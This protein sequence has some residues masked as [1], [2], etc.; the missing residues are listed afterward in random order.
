MPQSLL[1][2]YQDLIASG[3]IEPEASQAAAVDALQRLADA[4][5]ANQ[6]GTL[7]SLWSRPAAVRGLYLTGPVG[8]GKTM[9]MDLFFRSV[10]GKIKRRLHFDAFMG[11]A[12]AA[13]EAARAKTPGDPI[14]LA[15]RALAEPGALL[16]IDEFQVNDIADAMII[17]RLYEQLVAA[18]VTLVAT[19]NTLPAKLY[20]DGINRPLF[21][22]FVA[23][24]QKHVDVIELSARRDY[25][26]SKLAGRPLY[27]TPADAAAHDALEASWVLLTNNVD[28][29]PHTLDI[30]GR[31][32]TIPRAADGTAWIGF[33][34]LCGAA[35]GAAD[36]RALA[37][38]FHTLILEGIPILTPDHR[39]EARRLILLIDVLYDERRHLIA[40]AAAE[41][42]QLYPQG[43]GHEAFGRTAS[44][45]VEMRS[46]DYLDASPSFK[47]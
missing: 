46:Q 19:S 5:A 14:P 2:A 34:A 42:H 11:E 18:G 3:A 9:L 22:P 1:S 44:R 32:L 31:K 20:P 12:H 27:F 13:I 43:D 37:L 16:C 21:L 28:G 39:N 25:R 24:L 7:A 38:H 36:Y 15:A 47:P 4:L 35:L 30:K 29:A 6:R 26:M 17:G 40:S 23:L 10:G 33:D 41:P 45:L 8:R